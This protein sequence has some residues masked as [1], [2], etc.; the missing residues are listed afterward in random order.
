MFK[1]TRAFAIKPNR[2]CF[3]GTRFY[4]EQPKKKQKKIKNHE[5]KK[6]T[7]GIIKV[8]KAQE[9]KQNYRSKKKNTRKLK[10][11]NRIPP[12]IDSFYN[13]RSYTDQKKNLKKLK[14]QDHLQWRAKYKDF[15]SPKPI[16]NS[17]K[18]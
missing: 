8:L 7:S 6:R 9:L 3:E 2:K 18:L 13:I 17:K 4:T 10:R 5:T 14:A 12:E 16:Q 1:I 11:L 15:E